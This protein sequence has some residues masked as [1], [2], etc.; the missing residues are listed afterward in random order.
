MNKKEL[1]KSIA[2]NFCEDMRDP[3]TDPLT[4]EEQQKIIDL[5]DRM[6]AH[7]PDDDLIELSEDA[8]KALKEI[9]GVLLK[10]E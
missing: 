5:W 2:E 8:L 3:Q 7:M 9:D 6:L 10:K 4:I 1:V